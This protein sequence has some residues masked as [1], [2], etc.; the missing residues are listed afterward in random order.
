MREHSVAAEVLKPDPELSLETVAHHPARALAFA[1]VSSSS[2]RHTETPTSVFSGTEI[3]GQLW[4]WPRCFML[5]SNQAVKRGIGR[6]E[7]WEDKCQPKGR[8]DGEDSGSWLRGKN[9]TGSTKLRCV[10]VWLGCGEKHECEGQELKG[11]CGSCLP[12]FLALHSLEGLCFFDKK[13]PL[14]GDFL[15]PGGC[16]SFSCQ[17]PEGFPRRELLSEAHGAISTSKRGTKALPCSRTPNAPEGA[18]AGCCSQTI[19]S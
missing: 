19:S 8:A 12:A 15:Q 16:A 1:S 3:Q 10:P 18:A 9:S 6:G 11:L 7:G 5:L 13:H 14:V 17:E 4:I 2:A